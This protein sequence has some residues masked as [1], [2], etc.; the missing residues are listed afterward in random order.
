MERERVTAAVRSAVQELGYAFHTGSE[1]WAVAQTMRLP[2]VWLA[3]PVL[4][5]T[6]GRRERRDTY[7][8]RLRFMAAA[9]AEEAA[10][11]GVWAAL[12]RDAS[13]LCDALRAEAWVRSVR[14]LKAVPEAKPLTPRGEAVV[15]AEF[16]VEVFYCN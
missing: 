16:E 6:A 7:G 12:E 1:V 15:T 11:E 13:A 2:A 8:V 9:M 4:K 10:A 5:R 3:A 14:G